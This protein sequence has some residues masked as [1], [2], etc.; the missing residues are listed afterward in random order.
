MTPFLLLQFG[1]YVISK[2]FQKKARY[3]KIPDVCDTQ[4]LM[5]VHLSDVKFCFRVAF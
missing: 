5:T 4:K 3:L 2:M 1:Q